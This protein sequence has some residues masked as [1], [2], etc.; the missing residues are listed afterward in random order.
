MSQ[1]VKSQRIHNGFLH[2][3]TVENVAFCA[4]LENAMYFNEEML[5]GFDFWEG[6]IIE[7]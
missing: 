1:N 2:R 7:D 3:E 4:I 5:P 6:E